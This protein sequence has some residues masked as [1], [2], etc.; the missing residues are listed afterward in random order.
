MI[1]NTETSHRKPAWLK[2]RL[3]SS[4]E[5]KKVKGVL[6][7]FNLHSV[8][9]EALCPNI[10]EC[11]AEGT[12]TLLILGNICTRNCLY[13][14][15]AQGNTGAVDLDEPQRLADA[16]RALGLR[17]VVITSVTRDDLADGG[18]EIFARCVEEL[19]RKIR[20][21]KVELLI[22]D[23][24]GNRQALARVM[25]SKPDVIN[26]NIDVAPAL[27][28]RLRPQGNYE[29]SLELLNRARLW[30]DRYLKHSA[31]IIKSGFMVGFGETMGNIIHLLSD[32]SKVQCEHLTIGQY[33]Q[34]SKNHWPVARYYAPDEFNHLKQTTIGM[35]F[36]R[37]EA[38][39]LVR[40]SYHAAKSFIFYTGG[41]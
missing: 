18:A 28:K 2:V 20:D 15:I 29:L 8:C 40:S 1:S 9:Q 16:A 24:K 7:S 14:N 30:R 41:A 32:L 35:G 23:F 38:G 17:Y 4:H 39:P 19:R 21:C 12:A 11:F 37:V 27:F 5:F 26:H 6:K 13:C 10:S 34:P 22:P 36:R 33:Q 3:P 25:D 31:I